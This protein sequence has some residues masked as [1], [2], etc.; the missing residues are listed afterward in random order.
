[1]TKS[2]I[3]R[4]CRQLIR[5]NKAQQQFIHSTLQVW[6][7]LELKKRNELSEKISRI[8]D[9]Y[10]FGVIDRLCFLFNRKHK[11]PTVRDF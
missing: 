5:Q 4:K 8:C 3:K 11:E 10:S 2:A 1:M 6:D 9:V 7:Q